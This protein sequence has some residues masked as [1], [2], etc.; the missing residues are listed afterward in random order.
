MLGIKNVSVR[1]T[2]AI[3]KSTINSTEKG[4][5]SKKNKQKIYLLIQCIRLSVQ[6]SIRINLLPPTVR[7]KYS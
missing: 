6:A 1:S 3:D 4:P 7:S 5:K 2:T